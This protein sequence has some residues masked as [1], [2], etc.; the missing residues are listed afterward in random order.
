MTKTELLSMDVLSLQKIIKDLTPKK[1]KLEADIKRLHTERQEKLAELNKPLP[2]L[3]SALKILRIEAESLSVQ[4]GARKKELGELHQLHATVHEH[5]GSEIA[6]KKQSLLMLD[7][8][9]DHEKEELAD[10]EKQLHVKN[11]EVESLTK[12]IQTLQ[13]ELT[14]YQK[15]V[16]LISN[17]EKELIV[18]L[19]GKVAIEKKLN[20]RIKELKRTHHVVVEDVL[21]ERNKRLFKRH[22]QIT[23]MN[24]ALD[25]QLEKKRKLLK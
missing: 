23:S 9:I 20:T 8:L 5:H 22:K 11:E 19:R 21:T 18:S 2:A 17:Q 1:E 16:L 15:T 6:N 25:I 12:N 14:N 7:T 24:K 3:E 4:I 13:F 10:V